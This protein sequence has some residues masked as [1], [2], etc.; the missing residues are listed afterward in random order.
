MVAP[1]FEKAGNEKQVSLWKD[2]QFV[3]GPK[4]KINVLNEGTA[5]EYPTDNF[6]PPYWRDIKQVQSGDDNLG[7]QFI[8]WP[9]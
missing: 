8:F 1:F 9:K 4:S 6:Y 2:G 5:A 7:K 3:F